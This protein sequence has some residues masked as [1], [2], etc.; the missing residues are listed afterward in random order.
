MNNELIT[1]WVKAV[2]AGMNE[3]LKAWNITPT[4]AE[5]QALG[6]A[7]KEQGDKAFAEMLD[8]AKDCPE[9][10]LNTLAATQAMSAALKAAQSVYRAA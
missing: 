9:P 2:G 6:Q 1:R 5:W 8:L 10:L 7:M 3:V 4:E